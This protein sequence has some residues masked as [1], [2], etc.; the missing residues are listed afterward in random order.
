MYT[1][2]TVAVDLQ[3]T[4]LLYL[5]HLDTTTNTPDE[6]AAGNRLWGRWSA[7]AGPLGGGNE[8]CMNNISGNDRTMII[9]GIIIAAAAALRSAVIIMHSPTGLVVIVINDYPRDYQL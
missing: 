9:G 3:D 1:M 5:P 6:A 8:R 2:L 7:A 4:L